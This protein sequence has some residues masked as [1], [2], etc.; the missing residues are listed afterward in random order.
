[1][2]KPRGINS[3]RRTDRGIALVSVLLMLLLVS[4]VALGMIFM[5][6][7]E[8]SISA[9][10][11]DEQTA[12]FSARSGIEEVRDRSRSNA[13][14]TLTGNLPTTLP[15]NTQGVLYVTNPLGGEVVSPWNTSG[16]NY[17][18]DEICNEVTCTGGVPAGSPWYT[19]ASASTAYA[20]S[21]QLVWKWAR[22]TQK[23]NKTAGG[24]AHVDSVDGAS[25]GNLVCFNG[26]NEIVTTAAS[27]GAIN[28]QPVYVIT[29]LGV[30]SSG[31]RRMMQAE[32]TGASLPV[33]P[34]AMV[35]DGSNPDFAT[36]PHL[37]SFEV[38]GTDAAQ[39]PNG[40]AG[41]GAPVNQPALGAYDSASVTTLEGVLNRPASY[42][43]ASQSTPAVQNINSEL[44]SLATVDGLTNLANSITTSA[45]SNVFSSGSSPT[46]WGTNSAPVINV[47]NGDYSG[48]V[49]G[50]GILLVTGTLTLSAAPTY[51][52]LILVIG[53]GN[54]S[55][56]NGGNG[57]L[58][59]SFFVANLYSDAPPTYTNLIPLGHS[60]PP[61]IPTIAW[62]GGSNLTVQYDS[63]WISSVEQSPPLKILAE[64]E[65][66]K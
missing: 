45:G 28:A 57:A 55:K 32:A 58:N 48:T 3:F 18:D 66:M 19:T 37:S 16:T 13:T 52:G 2:A 22:V 59:G 33:F 47:I 17:P 7:T 15:G 5:S 8:T 14:N 1:M 10:F 63:C 46:N 20:A 23:T 30:T 12:Y 21:P 42:T 50:A 41:C 39:G 36:N 61:G 64:H 38:I 54:V 60:N 27:C 62:Q 34:G 11:R 6:D 24:T 35:F 65:V 56:S 51:N 40:G 49:T 31:S 53:K 29:T 26:T 9:N 43:E 25:N 4:A 44:G